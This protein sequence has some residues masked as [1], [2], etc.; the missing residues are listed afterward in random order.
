MLTLKPSSN[1]YTG[2]RSTAESV[3]SWLQSLIRHFQPPHLNILLQ[4]FIVINQSDHYAQTINC[5]LINLFLELLLALTHFVVL[6]HLSGTPSHFKFALRLLSQLL[7]LLLKH[8]SSATRLPKSA[9][10]P[11]LRFVSLFNFIL[12]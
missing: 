7:N 2:Y 8:T 1:S 3:S 4:L 9:S 6:H 12:I 11:S 10:P 5:F